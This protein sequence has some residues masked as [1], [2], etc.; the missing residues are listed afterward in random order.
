MLDVT[1]HGSKYQDILNQ[2]IHRHH[3]SSARL[4]RALSGRMDR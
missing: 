1:L 3:L 2:K 4:L